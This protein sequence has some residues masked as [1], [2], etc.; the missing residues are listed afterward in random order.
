MSQPVARIRIPSALRRWTSQQSIIECQG[1]TV[2]SVLQNL[3]Q[4]FPELQEQLFDAQG[5]VRKFINIY[6]NEDDI[7][8]LKGLATEVQ[9][10][11]EVSIMAAIAGG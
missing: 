7:R 4:R 11:D 10:R 2:E 8:F 9:A 5:G 6:L 3:C 1:D